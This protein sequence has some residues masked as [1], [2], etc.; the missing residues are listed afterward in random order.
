MKKYSEN[1]NLIED[2]EKI[3]DYTKHKEDVMIPGVYCKKC[4]ETYTLYK[5]S[6]VIPNGAD[7]NNKFFYNTCL[8]CEKTK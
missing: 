7:E 6:L 4:G 5:W 3:P 8:N 1:G 2:Y